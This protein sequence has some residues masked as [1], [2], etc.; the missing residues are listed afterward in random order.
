MNAPAK[1]GMS[2]VWAI[3]NCHQRLCRLRIQEGPLQTAIDDLHE[4]LAIAPPGYPKHSLLTL[5]AEGHVALG[6]LPEA[7][8]ALDQALKT[9]PGDVPA[10]LAL[11]R[12]LQAN[13]SN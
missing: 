10:H 9:H 12:L 11:S 5:L 1:D 8:A 6:E 4:A 2:H 13:V 3:T 7:Q